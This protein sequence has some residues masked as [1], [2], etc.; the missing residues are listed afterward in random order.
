MIKD[1]QLQQLIF[2]EIFNQFPR[3][4]VLMQKSTLLFKNTLLYQVIW[5][6]SP[7]QS[8]HTP[9]CHQKMQ[10][11][12]QLITMNLNGKTSFNR[13]CWR[14]KS[15]RFYHYNLHYRWR[16]KSNCYCN[17]CRRLC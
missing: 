3:N 9:Y 17:S 7:V 12:P 14:Y 11:S 15:C 8:S 13:P 1:D 5:V 4:Q 10:L 6:W 16:R 2:Q